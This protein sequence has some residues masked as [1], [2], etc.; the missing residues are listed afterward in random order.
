MCVVAVLYTPMLVN[1]AEYPARVNEFVRLRVERKQGKNAEL[2]V[3]TSVA[4]GVSY[5]HGYQKPASCR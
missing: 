1:L 4:W 2:R 5:V 3:R